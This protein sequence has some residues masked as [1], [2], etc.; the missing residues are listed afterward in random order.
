M[1]RLLGIDDCERL[2]AEAVQS[3]Y[4]RHVN[5]GQVDLIGAFGFGRDL[6]DR[7]EGCSL[8]TRSGRDILDFTG[9]IG[10]LNHGHNHPRILAARRRFQERLH[11]EVH[12]NYLSPYLAALSHNIAQLLPGDL[13]IA[14]F[15]NSGAEAVEGALKLAY[16]SH[17]G[18]R[19]AVLHADISYHGKLLG[20]ASVSGS[21]ELHF[22]FPQ[23]PGTHAFTYG[24]IDSVQALVSR[25]RRPDGGSDLY[26]LIV[27]PFSAS[28]LRAC[29][30]DFLHRLRALCDAEGI[31][32]IFDEVFTGW[33]KTGALFHFM[34]HDVIPDVVVVSKA[35]G[36]GKASIAGY[37]A[38]RPIFQ[39]A[40][41]RLHDATLHSTTYNGFGEECFTAIEAVNVVVE[42]DYP[43]RARRI[44]A[45][46]REGLD[47]IAR[48]LPAMVRE[49]RGA[50]AHQ[51]LLLTGGPPAL[52]ALARLLPVEFLRDE[53]FMCKLVTGAAINRLY[54]RHGIL[55]YFAENREILLM[56]SPALVVEDAA[57][58]R[59]LAALRETLARGA[60]ALC[61]EFAAS[62][63]WPHTLSRR[64]PA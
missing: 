53:R 45:R 33:G 12:K 57:V 52:A 11:M 23:I 10:V 35:L 56:A 19:N 8:R 31:V 20:A 54:E 55:T 6:V 32:L 17:G 42:D 28:S 62:R 40:Y 61:L 18:R 4:R 58:D 39:R 13:E 5:A 44:G 49:V 60:A 3:L 7:A 25:L 27:E 30:G 21:R 50:G 9:G 24:D 43:G 16:K 41:G 34:H 48:D 38:R 29:S 37:V 47:R 36:G 51:G 15:P 22:R 46:L 2:D 64:P 59:Y 26:A 63:F 1:N 14:Y